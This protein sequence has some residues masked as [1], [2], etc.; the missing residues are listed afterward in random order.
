MI[1]S[2]QGSYRGVIAASEVHELLGYMT[3]GGFMFGVQKY[4][5]L[6]SGG[7]SLA[8]EPH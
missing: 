1:N 3:K 7:V 2:P 6:V 5:V 4:C 8:Q